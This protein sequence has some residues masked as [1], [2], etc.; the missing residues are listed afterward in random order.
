MEA[1]GESNS[2]T[3]SIR[4]PTRRLLMMLP[5]QI[6]DRLADGVLVIFVGAVEDLGAL[7]QRARLLLRQ[8][9]PALRQ[10]QVQ[11]CNLPHQIHPAGHDATSSSPRLDPAFF[12]AGAVF[13][14]GFVTPALR[15]SEECDRGAA[16][17]SPNRVTGLA[18][19]GYRLN[20]SGMPGFP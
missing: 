9:I 11:F 4:P 16:G 13:S 14:T 6:V 10:L 7:A 15:S 12:G 17:A 3:E 19:T 5:H 20:S 18:I 2:V 1:T 8:V